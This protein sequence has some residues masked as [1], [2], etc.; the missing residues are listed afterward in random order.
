VV[1]GGGIG[2]LTAAT[3]L[4]AKGARVALLE[5]YVIPGGSAG[6]FTRGEYTFDVG[7]SMMFG[8]GDR[9][10]LNLLTRALA[11][12]GRKLETI[13]DANQIVYHLPKSRRFT[14]GLEVTVPAEGKYEEFIQHL[15]SLFPEES[16]GIR[17]FYDACWEVFNSLN[18]C[19]L[20]SLEDIGYL[21]E[22][23]AKNPAAGVTLLNFIG[24]NV[25]DVARKYIK[26]EELLRIIDIECF[27]FSTIRADLTPFINAGVVLSDRHFGGVRYPRGGVGQIAKNLAEGFEEYGGTLEY[28]ANV[29]KIL[30]SGAGKSRRACGVQLADGRKLRAKKV[31]SNAT[32]WATFQHLMPAEAMPDSEKVF[33]DRYKLSPSFVSVH[34]AV[35]ADVIPEDDDCHHIFLDD[36]KLLE[37]PKGVLF[38]SIPSLLDP[39]LC[40]EGTHIVHIFTPDWIADWRGLSS[41][42]YDAKKEE[43]A[44]DL[45]QRMEVQWPGISK[46][47]LF[48][49][50]GSPKTHRRFLGRTDGS[51]GPVPTKKLNGMLAMPLSLTDVP[52]LYCC[53]DSTFPGQGVN[54]VALSGTFCA[55]RVAMDLGLETRI[56]VADTVFKSMLGGVQ[57][58][59]P[60]AGKA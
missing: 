16:V 9:G 40:P 31:V 12:V 7:S 55:H 20:K 39:S 41:E 59:G 18:V 47:V 34:M 11:V 44:D 57:H 35:R 30:V 28:G 10:Y 33:L 43:V 22:V 4:V 51:Y 32:R 24:Q 36:W 56:P 15:S 49:E 17:R 45:M 14:E 29:T 60:E 37:E 58:I 5:K 50:I 52:G 54:A 48:R 38:V 2:G 25:G 13:P 23:A 42:A 1:I 6:A 26:N 27:V 53:G 19:E 46:A 8:F 3:N 21:L